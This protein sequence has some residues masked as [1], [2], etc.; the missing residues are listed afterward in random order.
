MFSRSRV[1]LSVSLA[2]R[3]AV[4]LVVVGDES[5]VILSFQDDA[6]TG[7]VTD[8]LGGFPYGNAVSQ[9]RLAAVAHGKFVS[10]R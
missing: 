3:A 6:S 1:Y 4:V 10:L 7:G 5:D 2:A 9:S 8:Q